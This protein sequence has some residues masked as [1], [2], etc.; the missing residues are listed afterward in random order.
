[1]TNVRHAALALAVACMAT[2]TGRAEEAPPEPYGALS[3]TATELFAAGRSQFET[4][5]DPA[6]GLGPVFNAES[7]ATCHARPTTGGSSERF[8]TRFGRQRPDGFDPLTE[9]GG[10]VIQAR[11]VETPGCTVPGEVVP[12]AATIVARRDTPPLYGVGLIDSIPD[13]QILRR[14]DP[15]DRDGD[16]VRGHPNTVR[17][18][19]ARFGWKAQIVSVRQFVATAYLNELGVTSPDFPDELLP[20]GRPAL[21]DGAHD[22]EDDGSRIDAVTRFLVFLAPLRR[23]PDST[24]ARAGR[25]VFRRLGC[26]T[27]HTTALRAGATAPRRALRDRRIPM[28]SDLLLHDMGPELADGIAQGFATG[29]EFRT[30]PLWGVRASAPYLHDGRAATL[31]QAITLHGGEA[32]RA[33]ERFAALPPFR[34]AALIAFLER[35]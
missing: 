21:C 34:R 7:C 35:I 13:R 20:Q 12:P 27:C 15:G 4:R 11:G 10:P 23:S 30:T 16:G 1:M 6:S 9:L 24:T 8:V 22:P 18:R 32:T 28:F 19:V 25:I 5:E 33:R 3:P 26:E 17:G 14:A 2:A 29:S 31:E